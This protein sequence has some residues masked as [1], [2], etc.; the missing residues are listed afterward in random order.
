MHKAAQLVVMYS[1]CEHH[2]NKLEKFKQIKCQKSNRRGVARQ[3]DFYP[4]DGQYG[5]RSANR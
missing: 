1:V 5:S 4:K 2:N 3:Q